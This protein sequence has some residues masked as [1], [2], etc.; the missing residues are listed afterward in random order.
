METLSY[1]QVQAAMQMAVRNMINFAE[2]GKAPAAEKE[3]IQQFLARW[4]R[5]NR[6]I[7]EMP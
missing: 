2:M 4:A 6:V 5:A 3:I 7:V 1:Y